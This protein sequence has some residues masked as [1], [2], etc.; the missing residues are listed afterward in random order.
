M[1]PVI[2]V[3]DGGPGCQNLALRIVYTVAAGKGE[4]VDAGV[5]AGNLIVKYEGVGDDGAGHAAG[6][7]HVGHPQQIGDC[8]CDARA[9]LVQFVEDFGG[10]VDALLQNFCCPINGVLRN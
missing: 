1:G 9:G 10:A 6:L 4:G 3:Q 2:D 5:H 8:L 7:A